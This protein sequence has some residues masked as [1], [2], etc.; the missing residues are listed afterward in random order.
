MTDD[1]DVL[2]EV[3][4]WRLESL[5]VLR[6]LGELDAFT[7]PRV[8]AILDEVVGVCHELRLIV[9]LTQLT[10]MASTGLGLLL[11]IRDRVGERGGHLIVILAPGSRPR[12]LFDLTRL[13]DHF[14]VAESLREAVHALRQMEHAPIRDGT[15]ETP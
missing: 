9:D 10:F 3:R 11:E 2:L 8:R 12:R 14:E 15:G 1:S 6:L 5:R 13:T 4:T 7:A